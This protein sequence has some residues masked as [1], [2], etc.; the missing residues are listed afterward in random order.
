MRIPFVIFLFLLT[1]CTTVDRKENHQ[2]LEITRA[3]TRVAVDGSEREAAWEAT[4]WKTLSHSW[5]GSFPEE[6]DLRGKYKILWDP[7]G[8]YLLVEIRDD[9]LVNYTQ[10]PMQL[11]WMEDV[12]MIY[13]DED[14][15][16]GLH[17]FNDNAFA[18]HISPDGNV[19]DLGPDRKAKLYNDHLEVACHPTG[20]SWVWEIKLQLFREGSGPSE[21]RKPVILEANKEIGFALGYADNDNKKEIKQVIGS[22]HIPSPK[23]DLAWINA[24]IF[25]TL[26]LM[27]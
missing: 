24:D 14:N 2:I 8:L 11:W 6:N 27:D 4:D 21:V 10:H 23:K 13:V 16:G 1:A 3:S 18:Y 19:I 25:G 15:S 17:Q 7:E 5:K 22:V 9:T 20:D 12:L 26:I